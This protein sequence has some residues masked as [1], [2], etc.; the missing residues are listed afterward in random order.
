MSELQG[1]VPLVEVTTNVYVPGVDKHVQVPGALGHPILFSGDQK[2]AARGRGAQ[3]AKMNALSPSA[4]LEG[5]V[6]VAADWHTK[7]KILDVC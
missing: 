4:R 7:V 5:L 2:T 3:K 1:Y 6:P